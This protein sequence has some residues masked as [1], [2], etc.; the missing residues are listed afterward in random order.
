M[1]LDHPK[2]TATNSMTEQDRIER[3]NRVYG[4]ALALAD[5]QG[6]AEFITKLRHIHDHKGVLTVVWFSEPSAIEKTY[7][8]KAWK[9]KIGD[10]TA[11]VEHKVE[12]PE[13]IR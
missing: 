8:I 1:Y 6:N 3:L 11:N 10:E 13:V 4:Y 5:A 12:S 2:I 7:F 9:S